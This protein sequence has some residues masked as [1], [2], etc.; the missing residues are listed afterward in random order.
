MVGMGHISY[1]FRSLSSC[2]GYFVCIKFIALGL[3][4]RTCPH[5]I[6]GVSHEIL[7]AQN[8]AIPWTTVLYSSFK[9]CVIR[10]EFMYFSSIHSTFQYSRFYPHAPFIYV[11][12]VFISNINTGSDLPQFLLENKQC[13]PYFAY[14]IIG[15][16]QN[17]RVR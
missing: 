6:N 17:Q 8:S 9:P 1:S 10:S 12:H 4:L 11:Y 15:H 5:K 7:A 14:L 16:T 3:V 13:L 2:I